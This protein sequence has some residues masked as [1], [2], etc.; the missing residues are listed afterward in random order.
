MTILKSSHFGLGLGG[1]PIGKKSG[2]PERL[3]KDIAA[4]L[5]FWALSLYGLA[6]MIEFI[7][8][9]ILVA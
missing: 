5:A 2:T 7:R 1:M 6:V 9:Y 8:Q 4:R 3:R